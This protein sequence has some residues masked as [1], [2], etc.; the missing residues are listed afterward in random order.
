MATIFLDHNISYEL[1][2]SE[3]E[4]QQRRLIQLKFCVDPVWFKH[5]GVDS[6][7]LESNENGPDKNTRREANTIS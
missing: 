3:P 4:W 6:E 5:H 7:F 1:P 2:R